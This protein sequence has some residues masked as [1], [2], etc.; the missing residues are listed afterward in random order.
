MG[1]GAVHAY[2]TYYNII[3]LESF[4][5]DESCASTTALTR[6]AAVDKNPGNFD[7]LRPKTGRRFDAGSTGGM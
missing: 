3:Y 4:E 5:D 1:G 7:T 6:A 2:T